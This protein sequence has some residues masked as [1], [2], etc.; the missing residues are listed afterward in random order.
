MIYVRLARW[1]THAKF[2]K[3]GWYSPFEIADLW[4]GPRVYL[5]VRARVQ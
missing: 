1:S 2:L 3:W 5:E 4:I